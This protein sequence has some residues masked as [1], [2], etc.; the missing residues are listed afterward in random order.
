MTGTPDQI[1]YLKL[2][3]DL[4]RKIRNF[5]KISTQWETD[6][7]EF[8]DELFRL[9]QMTEV[10]VTRWKYVQGETVGAIHIRQVQDQVDLTED[11]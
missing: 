6:D 9:L 1:E 11:Y 10:S 4:N 3:D 7:P 8:N 5:T 2:A